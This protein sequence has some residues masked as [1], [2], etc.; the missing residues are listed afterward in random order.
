[1]DSFFDEIY[2]HEE[3]AYGKKPN[4]YLKKQLMKLKPGK[5]LFPAEGEGRN[6]VFAAKLGWD[7]YCFDISK[8]AYKKAMKLAQE[9]DVNIKYEVC[10]VDQ[11]TYPK[12]SF[13]VIA[14][15]FP[16]K[17]QKQL[18]YF[19]KTKGFLIFESFSKRQLEYNSVNKF[20]GGPDDI[21]QLYS[22]QELKDDFRDFRITEL[23]EEEVFLQEGIYHN[24]TGSV[25]RFLGEYAGK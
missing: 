16:P 2:A 1:M 15:I 23:W 7:V 9:E 20:A 12:G 5:I 6:A 19:L 21:N 3:Y 11:L 13:D 14:L 10:D 25:I 8:N 17:I 18:I 22:T 4:E 24:G